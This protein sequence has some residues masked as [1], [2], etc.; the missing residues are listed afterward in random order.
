MVTTL[1]ASEQKY[2]R[3]MFQ[4]EP[5]AI[6]DIKDISQMRLGCVALF[7][8]NREQASKKEWPSDHSISEKYL[9]FHKL[10]KDMTYAQWEKWLKKQPKHLR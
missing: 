9:A 7:M 4:E 6:K 8:E 2:I 10:P 3:A 1:S 5:A